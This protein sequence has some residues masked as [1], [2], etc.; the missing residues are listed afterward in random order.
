MTG[1]E[2]SLERLR[3]RFRPTAGVRVLMIGES[4]PPGRGFF[5]SG[6][7]TLF[8]HTSDVMATVCGFPTDRDAS[9]DRFAAAGFFLEDLSPHRGDK[10]HMRPHADD[11]IDAIGR[12]ADLVTEEQPQVVVAVLREIR[13]IVRWIVARSER[14]TT[15]LR[16]LTFP[17]YRS[18]SAQGAYRR[19][20]RDVLIEFGCE[21]AGL[22]E[23][24]DQ[25]SVVG[26][27]NADR[28]LS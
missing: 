12:L 8:R 26:T 14:P 15:P 6:D 19:G 22:G 9:L 2:E 16:C 10:P 28:T 18:T 21:A 7:S 11:V 5:Y 24:Q 4:P 20:L 25:A 3:T 17:Y 23:S 1:D 27:P 13:D